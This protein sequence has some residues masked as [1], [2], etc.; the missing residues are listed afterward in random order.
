MP[1]QPCNDESPSEH[2]LLIPSLIV[3]TF[4]SQNSSLYS[5]RLAST[6]SPKLRSIA[7]PDACLAF[8]TEL[9][10][11]VSSHSTPCSLIR[12]LAIVTDGSWLPWLVERLEVESVVIP[13]EQSAEGVLV[14]V[15]SIREA[16]LSSTIVGADSCGPAGL[17]VP[18]LGHLPAGD[19]LDVGDGLVHVVEVDLNRTISFW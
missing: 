12:S 8:Q 11:A 15:L 2:V 19:F 13:V 3:R 17:A 4:Q 10:L 14:E 7:T 16:T 1:C 6:R 18:D 5:Q 9:G